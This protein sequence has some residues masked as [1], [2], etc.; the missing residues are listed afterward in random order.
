MKLV[1]AVLIAMIVTQFA[2]YHELSERVRVH[3]QLNQL[4][5]KAQLDAFTVYSKAI[6]EQRDVI[7]RWMEVVG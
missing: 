3:E 2:M 7:N 6:N 1:I 4:R 5:W